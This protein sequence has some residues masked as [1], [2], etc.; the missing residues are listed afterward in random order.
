MCSGV[1]DHRSRSKT[2]LGRDRVEFGDEAIKGICSTV[3]EAVLG[4]I[5]ST[6]L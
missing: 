3:T 5:V 6:I 4:L 1:S 2:L